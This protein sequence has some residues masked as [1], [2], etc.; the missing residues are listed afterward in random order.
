MKLTLQ[1]P[2]ISYNFYANH[3][4]TSTFYPI[5]GT[6]CGGVV[7]AL[8]DD[9]TCGVGVAHEVNLGGKTLL[10]VLAIVEKDNLLILSQW[11][12]KLV[13]VNKHTF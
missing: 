5:H 3:N 12:S 10:C 13:L 6:A 2:E 11:M 7:G 8:N 1:V 9:R 4:D